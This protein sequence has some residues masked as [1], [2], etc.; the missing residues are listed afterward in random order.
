MII[1]RLLI[2]P[3]PSPKLQ[4]MIPPGAIRAGGVSI[5]WWHYQDSSSEGYMRRR[6]YFLLALM[7]CCS[8]LSRRTFSVSMLFTPSTVP[9]NLAK[10][11]LLQ[12]TESK[13]FA[14]YA[15]VLR[16]CFLAI[17][18]L[19][20]SSSASAGI[21]RVHFYAEVA[22]RCARLIPD[23]RRGLRRHF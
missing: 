9:Q 20:A 12:V 5:S 19:I 14:G 4:V 22:N 1:A 8:Y 3:G 7:L 10:P 16:N 13:F 6:I 23:R 21:N 18:L 2:P 17:S 15:T 11:L